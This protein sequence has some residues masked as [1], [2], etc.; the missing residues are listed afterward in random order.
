MPNFECNKDV[1]Q[2]VQDWLTNK[3]TERYQITC[4]EDQVYIVLATVIGSPKYNVLIEAISYDLNRVTLIR[5]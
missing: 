1:Q 2:S 5:K 4:M 3:Q